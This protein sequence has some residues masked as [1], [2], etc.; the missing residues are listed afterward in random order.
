M[1]KN[2]LADMTAEKAVLGAILLDPNVLDGVFLK[3]EDF[4]AEKHQDIFQAMRRLT[5]KGIPP[6]LVSVTSELHGHISA[7]ELTEIAGDSGILSFVPHYC[8]MVRKFSTARKL[9]AACR[10]IQM[11][12]TEDGA[13]DTAEAKIMEIREGSG[14]EQTAVKVKSVL[15]PVLKELELLHQRKTHITGVATGFS[16][17]DTMTAGLQPSDL[18]IIAGRPSM[19]KT[20]LTLNIIENAAL[21]GTKSLVFS[22]EMRREQ[23][24]KRL[25]SSIG[26]VDGQRIRTGQFVESDWG[27][28]TNASGQL[29]DLPLWID[30]TFELSIMDL[31]AKARRHKRKHGLDLLAVDYLQLM[32]MPKAESHALAVGKITRSLKGLAKEL[33]VP[34]VCLSQLSRDLEKRT[35]KRP[36][37]SDLRDSG[38]IEQ[39]AD[40]VFF[41]YRE[42]VYCGD[43]KAGE[44]RKPQHE[45]WAEIIIGK[46]RSGP[47]GA[48]KLVWMGEHSKFGN[49][50]TLRGE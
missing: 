49:L 28:L 21:N 30:D 31:R 3:E 24:V 25:L 19:G 34:V 4:A 12:L 41:P 18:I 11:G 9:A 14:A 47:T 32:Q 37:M 7:V 5:D 23:L 42:A 10:E 17:L 36:L 6:D 15:G 39:D 26:R 44:C 38:S 50:D 48:V 45:K 43:C 40:V 27:R 29:A 16:E 20:A 35:D 2:I 8:G 33:N 22:L 46:Q 1:G 13:L